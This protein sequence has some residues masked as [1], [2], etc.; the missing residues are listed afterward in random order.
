MTKTARGR[1]IDTNKQAH[2]KTKLLDAAMKQLAEKSYRSITIREIAESANINGAMIAY[3][4]KNKEGLFIALLERIATQHF[5][6]INLVMQTK[7]PIKAFI[8]SML[9]MLHSNQF[10]ARLIHDEILTHE[11]ALRSAFIERFPKRMAKVLPELIIAHT[12]I[13]DLKNA[14]YSA[15]TLV[16]MIMM[17]FI[18]EPVRK[19]AWDI[20]DDEL[21][22]PQWAEHIYQTFM[23]GCTR[24]NTVVT[25]TNMINPKDKNHD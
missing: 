1:P 22:D 17:P 15:F 20:S 14:K 21:K 7:N 13:T 25:A 24:K 23:F 4:F 11:S 16:T 10:F 18:G 8:D 6:N 5:V 2:Q 19:Q 9:T 12:P 3:Y